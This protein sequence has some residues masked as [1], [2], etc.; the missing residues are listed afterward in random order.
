MQQDVIMPEAADVPGG[1]ELERPAPLAA[2]AA[3]AHEANDPAAPQ[4]GFFGNVLK[5]LAGNA[6]AAIISIAAYP[7]LAWV[8]APA[9][10]GILAVIGTATLVMGT[11]MSLRYEMALP[12]AGKEDE[13]AAILALSLGLLCATTVLL[14]I[15]L[16]LI[17]ASL[18]A[19]AGPVARYR[20]FLPFSVFGAGLYSLILV[21]ATRR[22]R[23]NDIAR[24]RIY[25]AVTGPGVQLLLGVLGAGTAGL[26]IGLVIGSASG[27]LGLVR[28]LGLVA[29]G[30]PLYRT[31]LAEVRAMAVK[32]RRFPLY[33]S[34]SALLTGVTG[35]MINLTF[36]MLYGPTIG[37]YLF[38]GDRV[39]SRPMQLL[40]MSVSQV[41]LGGAGWT[42]RNSPRQLRKL[43]R[44][45]AVKQFMIAVTWIGGVVICAPFV[46]PIVFGAKWVPAVIFIQYLAIGFF[47]TSIALPLMQAMLLIGKQHIA[48][49]IDSGRCVAIV[50][51]LVVAKM[52]GL[53][54]IHA[55]LLC[56]IVQLVGNAVAL[57]INFRLIDR[58]AR[59]A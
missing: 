1:A 23:Y 3:A 20:F 48:A 6:T 49:V 37:G 26:L 10:M 9:D 29:R 24:T 47:A 25:Q 16:W 39:L 38:L 11:V 41:F 51:A 42:V 50:S 31:N 28:R 52:T 57:T 54:P 5:L 21:E 27:T 43:V 56:A 12:T 30:A 4:A 22:A 59:S 36:A 14:A 45:I 58:F 34:W 35:N 44:D 46:V 32:H 13:A 7:M 55:V 53:T 8:Y 17:P 33:T 2:A 15:I 19:L 18:L 40:T